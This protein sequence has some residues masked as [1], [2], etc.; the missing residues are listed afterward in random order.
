MAG[1]LVGC[2][3]LPTD[4]TRLP[5]HAITGTENTKLGKLFANQKSD[6]AGRS[7]FYLLGSG[8]DAFAERAA[9]SHY[10]ERSIDVQYYLHHGDLIDHLFTNQLVKAAAGGSYL[11]AFAH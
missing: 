10:A 5:F 4:F 2:A 7:G 3:S 8:M 1:Y 9:L 6:D 11:E